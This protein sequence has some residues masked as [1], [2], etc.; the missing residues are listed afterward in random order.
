MTEDTKSQTMKFLHYIK[1]LGTISGIAG[2]LLVALNISISGYGFILFTISSI[3]WGVAAWIMKE[4]SL[5][6]LQGVFFVVNI[7]GITRWL[8]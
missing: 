2:S 1:W 3:S 4:N 7:I 6:I 5:L 8:F